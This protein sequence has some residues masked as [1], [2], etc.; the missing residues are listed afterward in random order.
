MRRLFL[1][2]VVLFFLGSVSAQRYGWLQTIRP[3][4]NEYCW[5]I[6]VDMFGN[7]VATGRV[8][9]NSIFGSGTNIQSPPM[10]GIET[11]VF[12]AK[13]DPNGNLIWVVRHGGKQPDWGRCI[14]SDING[15]VFVAGDY[16]D[17][18]YF[19]QDTVI[20][21]G[22]NLNRNIFLVKYDSTGQTQWV[23]SA[24]NSAGYSRAYGVCTDEFGN[25]Y[26]TGHI[27]GPSNFDG[28]SF[29]LTGKNIPFV[30]KF[31]Q[32]GNCLWVKHINCQFGGEGNDI[33]YSNGKLFVVGTYR[34]SMSIN[35]V[36]YPGNSPSWGDVYT[37]TLDTAGNFIW[38]RTAIGAYQDMANAIDLDDSLN[39]Y[40][41]GTFANDLSFGSLTINS[42]NFGATA[43]TAN[44]GIN[45]FVAK[46][47]P[48]GNLLWVKHIA[49]GTL[50]SLDDLDVSID[51][52][53]LISST[54]RNSVIVGDSVISY[55]GAN[56]SALFIAL[57]TNGDFKWKKLSGG[58]SNSIEARTIV[59]DHFGNVFVGGEYMATNFS[60]DSFNS[61]SI[62]GWDAYLAKLYPPLKPAI[63][64]DSVKCLG[65]T[66]LI[67]VIQ[68]G[69]PISYS[70]S[71]N[72]GQIVG[73]SNQSNLKWVTS[74]SGSHSIQL[75]LSNSFESNTIN[76]PVLVVAPQLLFLG[77]DTTICS[78]QSIILQA[79]PIFSSYLWSNGETSPMLVA[80]TPGQ[81]I[82]EAL[83][84]YGCKSSD[85][86]Q[87]FTFPIVQTNIGNDT[88]ICSGES[89]LLDAGSGFDQYQWSTGASSQSI[90]VSGSNQ[91][92]L[93]VI[94]SNGCS[95]LDSIV[96]SEFPETIINLGADTILCNGQN[97]SLVAPSGFSNFFW[98][99][100]E[101]TS[102]IE[103]SVSGQFYLIAED[104]NGCVVKDT[105]EVGFQDCNSIVNN[106]INRWIIYPTITDLDPIFIKA[107][108]A[109]NY[110]YYVYNSFSRVVQIGEFQEETYIDV[111]NFSQGVY[112]VLIEHLESGRLYFLQ[113][114]L[115][116]HE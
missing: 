94:D 3:G 7:V 73:L 110:V 80:S 99:T 71:S 15:N 105:V 76:I 89:I 113:K 83:D 26:I 112:H 104:T 90:S 111:K 17:T 61:S 13:Y 36:N 102:F 14:S 2:H 52:S 19:E 108:S 29:G 12:A 43:A 115:V 72:S 69:N 93:N 101:N 75:S 92:F 88:S 91:I 10:I 45:G 116:I 28:V 58:G 60:F 31:N 1:F 62:S 23:K 106:D 38:V 9:S 32:A 30:A 114:F 20:G 24:G 18:A 11:D 48:L 86:I 46:Y 85:T 77:F 70:W 78:G 37:A 40:I 41:A 21:I 107:N 109:G 64:F 98:S 81:L 56:P 4:G 42:L 97:Y 22:N 53:V 96:I 103:I 34:G 6:D 51:G 57:S 65:D 27:S 47:N 63:I 100:G 79:P 49:S 87:V 16:C 39:V 59:S 68:S 55:T 33:K 54:A 67:N 25:S 44:A 5:D 66:L 35:S 8:K 82:L 95:L 50:L 74:T 84:Q